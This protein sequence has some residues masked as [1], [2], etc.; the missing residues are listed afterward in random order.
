MY[1]IT[2][3]VKG[4][5]LLLLIVAT[6][7]LRAQL[8]YIEVHEDLKKQDLKANEIILID[9]QVKYFEENTEQLSENLTKPASYIDEFHQ[10]LKRSASK[11]DFALTIHRPKNVKSGDVEQYRLLGKFK[12]H[13]RSMN[14]IQN[15]PLNREEGFED[16]GRVKNVLVEPSRVHPEFAE[17]NDLFNTPYY[18]VAGYNI[19]NREQLTEDTPWLSYFIYDIQ[20]YFYFILADVRSGEVV[21]R[22]IKLFEGEPGN[23]EMFNQL[24]DTFFNLEKSS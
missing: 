11:N 16:K 9:P 4:I 7:P 20:N 21:Y 15:H 17:M 23:L 18:A 14:G 1:N 2:W 5:T 10:Y 12:T 3:T 24:Y 19:Y 8:Y 6:V 22:E 13:L